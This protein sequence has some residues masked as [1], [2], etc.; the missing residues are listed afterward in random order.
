MKTAVPLGGQ[1]PTGK[2]PPGGRGGF[3]LLE[4]ILALAI[5]T[6]ALA[7]LAE[8]ASLGMRHARLSRYI[9]RAELL[10]NSKLAEITSG[11]TLPEAVS[12]ASFETSDGGMSPGDPTEPEWRY[13]VEVT[14]LDEEGLL[15]VRVTVAQDLPSEKR[16][17]V[18]S[19]VRWIV[20][21]GVE[22]SEEVR[23]EETDPEEPSSKSADRGSE[24]Q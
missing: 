7:V 18:F 14:S 10:S 6:G 23:S 16:P 8:L 19:L 9:T 15:A 17:V 12:N 2:R 1:S 4:V 20:D 3:S 24:L 22:L 11:I 13:S 5:L 21:P